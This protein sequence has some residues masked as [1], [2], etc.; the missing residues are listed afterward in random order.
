MPSVAFHTLGCKVNQYETEAMTEQFVKAGYNIGEFDEKNDIYIVNTCTV[1]NIADKKS[2]KMLSRAKKNNPHGIVVA[3]G[4]YVQ[5]QHEQLKDMPYIDLLIGNTQK[6][7]LVEIVQSFQDQS[8]NIA[9]IEDVHHNIVFEELH[10]EAQQNKT[11][12]TLKI[13][14]GCDQYCSYCIIPYT[15][16]IVRSRDP[17]AVINEVKE[18]VLHGYQE[19]VLTGIHIGSYGKDLEGVTLIHLIEQLNQIEGLKRIR[20][21]SVEPGLISEEFVQRL[22]QCEKVCPHFHLSMQSGSDSVLKRMNRKYTSKEYYEKV[23]LLRR[24]YT[25]PALTTDVIVGFPMETEK[26]AQTTKAFVEK[27]AFSDV[28]VFK[29]SIREGTKAAKMTPQVDGEV[30]NQRSQ[31]LIAT[32]AQLKQD[33]LNRHLE[34]KVQVLIEEEIE[35]EGKMFLTGYTPEYIRV[36]IQGDIGLKGQIIHVDLVELFHDGIRGEKSFVK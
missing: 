9:K 13:Q 20:I 36:Y 6:N 31:E 5:I 26:E 21:G 19:I 29:Y 18:L 32:T 27:V 34:A 14:D 1:T 8:L 24:Y 17:Q 2:R 35:L 7:Q 30:K 15:R 3:V 10:I 16:G 23:E 33:Y 4:C 28:H 25:E 11:R 22:S 12:S